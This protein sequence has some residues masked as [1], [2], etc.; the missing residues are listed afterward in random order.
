M[1]NI[2]KLVILSFFSSPPY[3]GCD[4]MQTWQRHLSALWCGFAGDVEIERI[5]SDP[6]G[7]MHPPPLSEGGYKNPLGGTQNQKCFSWC[8]VPRRIHDPNPNPNPMLNLFW[9]ICRKE[10]SENSFW[11]VFHASIFCLCRIFYW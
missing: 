4:L 6:E 11:G 2:H 10:I 8:F 7:G 1:Q 9:F 3:G 5:F